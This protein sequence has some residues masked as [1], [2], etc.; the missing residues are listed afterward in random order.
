[1]RR[2]LTTPIT[3]TYL[4]TDGGT[5]PCSRSQ[6]E[7]PCLENTRTQPQCSLTQGKKVHPPVHVHDAAVLCAVLLSPPIPHYFWPFHLPS[8]ALSLMHSTRIYHTG[9]MLAPDSKH[10]H[11]SLF[12]RD[13]AAL[14][15]GRLK[16]LNELAKQKERRNIIEHPNEGSAIIITDR[17]HTTV[18]SVVSPQTPPADEY[19]TNTTMFR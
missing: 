7:F 18:A 1:M 19:R 14:I 5:L 9:L 10:G 12:G 2:L 15:N 17:R 6:T 11:P 13:V 8:S 4:S 16:L 3:S